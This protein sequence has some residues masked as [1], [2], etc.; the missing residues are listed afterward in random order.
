MWIFAFMAWCLN[1][2]R[3]SKTN[4]DY[5]NSVSITFKCRN[6]INHFRL[7]H[8]LQETSL[9]VEEVVCGYFIYHF[10]S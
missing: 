4:F 5:L 8:T 10:M 9:L 2:G 1:V 3:I 7:E 6:Y